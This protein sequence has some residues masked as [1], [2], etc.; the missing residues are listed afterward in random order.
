VYLARDDALGVR[1]YEEIFDSR[2][3]QGAAPMIVEAEPG[4]YWVG[5]EI[6]ASSG[7]DE[8]LFETDEAFDASTVFN[9]NMPI[10]YRRVYRLDIPADDPAQVIGLFQVLGSRP[11]DLLHILSPGDRF[12]I[13][14]QRVG[15]ALEAH[16]ISS[17][18]CEDLVQILGAGGK[19]VLKDISGPLPLAF[20]D[21]YSRFV[22]EAD[23]DGDIHWSEFSIQRPADAGSERK[24]PDIA[25]DTKRILTDILLKPA[26]VEDVFGRTQIAYDEF[27]PFYVAGWN[28]LER[29]RRIAEG[30]ESTLLEQVSSLLSCET[31]IDR[32]AILA[33]VAPSDRSDVVSLLVFTVESRHSSEYGSGEFFFSEEAARV[34]RI[35]VEAARTLH[36]DREHLALTLFQNSVILYGDLP[37]CEE[38]V[39][40]DLNE[41]CALY[42][43]IPGLAV[44]AALVYEWL[45]FAQQKL[46]QYSAARQAFLNS[47]EW[48]DR[49]RSGGRPRRHGC[50]SARQGFAGLGPHQ[51][52]SGD[53]QRG[54]HCRVQQT[55][56]ESLVHSHSQLRCFTSSDRRV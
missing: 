42:E 31:E 48:L 26:L 28:I 52:R 54:G 15:E 1:P 3:K 55:L 38:E 49:T 4:T 56:V 34:G 44:G 20:V 53:L 32:Q 2:F 30:G 35:T 37:R 16:D 8:L 47:C 18:D 19:V 24:T 36:V 46:G 22:V 17:V 7:H 40:R 10:A 27:G 50:R 13:D 14:S 45:G 21:R 51:Q 11:T 39:L 25:N 9:A 43:E 29:G 23:R 12:R 33:S 6:A 5:F 41:V